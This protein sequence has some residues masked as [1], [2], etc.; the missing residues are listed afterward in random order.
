MDTPPHCCCRPEAATN[1]PDPAR[2]L[3]K[4]S[5]A[6]GSSLSGLSG[7]TRT[8]RLAAR[9]GRL[10]RPGDPRAGPGDADVSGRATASV[11]HRTAASR[12]ETN[13]RTAH[14]QAVPWHDRFYHSGVVVPAMPLPTVPIAASPPGHDGRVSRRSAASPRMV[15]RRRRRRFPIRRTVRL[16]PS[17]STG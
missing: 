7:W 15:S 14:T 10:H 6:R 16:P 9:G 17:R 8:T 12:G 2:P 13:G 1:R 5:R 3:C 11:G 4:A